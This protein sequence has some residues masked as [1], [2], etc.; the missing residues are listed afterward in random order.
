MLDGE[1]RAAFAT[2]LKAY[3]DL[4]QSTRDALAQL[5]DPYRRRLHAARLAK[6][7]DE[8]QMAHQTPEAQRTPAPQRAGAA[9]EDFDEE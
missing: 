7:S 6:L 2:A 1:Q 5:E 4:T 9:D 8:A 3:Q